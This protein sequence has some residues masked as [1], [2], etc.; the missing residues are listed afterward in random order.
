MQNLVRFNEKFVLSSLSVTLS[1]QH[2]AQYH[3]HQNSFALNDCVGHRIEIQYL[4]QIYCVACGGKTQKSFQQGHCFSCVRKLAS[5]DLCMVRPEKCHF[6][7]GTCRQPVWGE[8][9]C[10]QKH[11]VYLANTSN[12]KIGIARAR[13]IPTRWLNQGAMQAICIASVS[14]RLFSGLL[15]QQLSHYYADKTQWQAMLKSDAAYIDLRAMR[16]QAHHYLN[17]DYRKN[18]T[19]PHFTLDDVSEPLHITYPIASYPTK[20][21]AHN[22]D[23]TPCV[24]GVLTGIKGQYL[25][26]D[27]GVLNMRKFSGYHCHVTITSL[28]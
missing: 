1:A 9:N 15:E 2:V 6:H 5:C 18:T 23:K 13:N 11:V 19:Q 24:S 25:M 14:E 4:G 16:T 21:I 22:L 3:L 28:S 7:V 20:I 8:E 12:L 26:L 27:S 10:M 17:N